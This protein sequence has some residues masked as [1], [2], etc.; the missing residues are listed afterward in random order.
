MVKT[1]LRIIFVLEKIYRVRKGKVYTYTFSLRTLYIQHMNP[2]Y[3]L[4]HA[5]WIISSYSICLEGKMADFQLIFFHAQLKWL[6]LSNFE[7]IVWNI[8]LHLLLQSHQGKRGAWH[9]TSLIL[10]KALLPPTNQ[11]TYV[12]LVRDSIVT[13]IHFWRKKTVGAKWR[14]SCSMSWR[15][16][17]KTS[18]RRRGRLRKICLACCLESVMWG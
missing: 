12:L 10:I 6:T 9:Q 1:C 17:P 18:G 13:A 14:V 4:N 2:P 16:V 11:F 3:C 5:H 15:R 8:C 7:C